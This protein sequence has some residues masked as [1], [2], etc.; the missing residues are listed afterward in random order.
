MRAVIRTFL[1]APLAVL[2]AC[3][4][5]RAPA[6]PPPEP[7]AAPAPPLPLA[8][9]PPPA[10]PGIDPDIVDR[11]VNPCDD[12]YAFACNG[13]LAKT[14][15]PPDRT[16]W[17][18][19]FDVMT[20]RKL[21]RLREILDRAAAGEV[22]PADR[23][24]ELVA[25]FYA[26]CMDEERI[27]RNGL[28]DLRAEWRALEGVKDAAGLAT[29][30]GRL[31]R[32]AVF[33][34]FALTSA[35]DARDSS[36]VIGVLRQGGLSLPD[37]DYYLKP[38]AAS[39]RLRE[40][41][42]AHVEKLLSLAGV[43]PDRA[44][45]EART[46][47]EVES[48]LA[49]SHFTR[50]EMRD[51]R[52]TYNRV[53]LAGLRQAAPEFDWDRYLSAA[54][55]AGVTAFSTTTPA[56]LTEV[57]ELVRRL[58]PE[59]W[60][61]YLRWHVLAE[62]AQARALP[63]SLSEEAFWFRARHF[64]GEKAMPERWRHCVET[65]DELLGQ[66]LG[67]AFVRRFFGAEARTDASTLIQGVRDAMG[68]SLS[69]RKWMDAPTREK[70]E[71]KLAAVVSKIGY[72]D[73]WQSYQGLVIRR[74]D[75]YGSVR[76]ARAF[77][78]HRRLAQIGKPPD[79]EEWH[80]TPPT[81]NAYYNA[82]LN[83]IVFPAGILQPPLFTEGAN[84]AVNYGAIGLVMGHELSHGFDD[85]GRQYDGRG[86]LSDWWTPAV[87]EEFV[88]RAGCLERQFSDYVAVDDLT[89]N[90]KLTLGENIADLGGLILAWEAYRASRAGQPPEAPVAGFTA[91][92]QFFL[93]HAQAWCQL[94]RPENAR[95]RV[96]TD[97]HSPGRWRVNG[98]LS[99]MPA[100]QETFAC[101]PGDRMAR[102]ERCEIW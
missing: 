32:R 52:R 88:R 97:P 12:F 4:S 10:L 62:A 74:G 59:S 17:T 44:A 66:A 1:A 80:M 33:P 8:H 86:N 54:G 34:L 46:V 76:S 7:P 18:R 3:A 11:S 36:E 79:R 58:P 69:T 25:D 42:Q 41:F 50:A 72:P 82:A 47:L 51:P 93:A 60:R 23:Y 71:E 90:G 53:D 75:F 49:R 37:R 26:G 43:P 13:W 78:E 70:A 31:H 14:E 55:A 67:Q 84:D 64:G 61:A 39:V 16:R 77:E 35:Q 92:Q 96:V 28:S 99:N 40:D 22:D 81:V 56:M 91:E 20:E 38:D 100:F 89:L 65:T 30:V 27:E 21:V 5:S 98:P 45:A 19:S 15:I 73:V 95:L 63:R 68:R 101:Q 24:G 102:T 85:H 9:A 2:L 94:V 6:P 87:G 29:A 57:E 48:E 83:E